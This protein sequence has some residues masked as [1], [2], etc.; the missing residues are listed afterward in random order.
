M[1]AEPSL[2]CTDV[3]ERFVNH[4]QPD[5][6]V[7]EVAIDADIEVHTEQHRRR[8]PDGEQGHV[9]GDVFHPVQEENHTEQEQDVVVSRRHVLG[10][11]VHEGN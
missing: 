3:I 11:Q 6:G 1:E 8:V 4:R 9:Q 7:N 10:A 5:D 2:K